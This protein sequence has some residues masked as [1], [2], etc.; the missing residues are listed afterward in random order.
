MNGIASTDK[1]AANNDHYIFV[2]VSFWDN[3]LSAP[4]FSSSSFSPLASLSHIFTYVGRCLFSQRNRL[5]LFSAFF[6][7]KGICFCHWK[8]SQMNRQCHDWS[9]N[10]YRLMQF[11]LVIRYGWA[12]NGINANNVELC[13]IACSRTGD[14]R[15]IMLPFLQFRKDK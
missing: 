7:K 5:L 12:T 13:F 4:S 15:R 14:N 6:R 2:N 9:T 3:F 8:F 1:H 11:S 10:N